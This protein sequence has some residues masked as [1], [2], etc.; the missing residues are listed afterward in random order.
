MPDLRKVR[1]WNY[2]S[3]WVSLLHGIRSKNIVLYVEAHQ[4]KLCSRVE[5]KLRAR[6]K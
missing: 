1:M 2:G 5:K 3:P 6:R 4:F